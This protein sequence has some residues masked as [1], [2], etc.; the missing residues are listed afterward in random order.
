MD[1]KSS[2]EINLV[3]SFVLAKIGEGHGESRL[4]LGG[5]SN[6][7]IIESIF[8]I[9]DPTNQIL[10]F[11]KKNI[12]NVVKF[13]E[14]FFINPK[15]F[16]LDNGKLIS[17]KQPLKKIFEEN[18]QSLEFKREEITEKAELLSADR[19]GRSYLRVKKTSL[20]RSYFLPH[21]VKLIMKES[22]G[23]IKCSI[24]P[25]IIPIKKPIKVNG[26]KHEVEFDYLSSY[27]FKREN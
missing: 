5:K 16:Y 24:K 6:K 7:E 4:Y 1:L 23:Y 17:F 13:F 27:D 26:K 18:M 3:D 2:I 8:N 9:A 14:P 19:S 11:S 22:Q 12:I 21:S 20:L 25:E 15:S 10:V